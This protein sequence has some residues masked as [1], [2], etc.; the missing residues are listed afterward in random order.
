MYGPPT[1]ETSE[2]FNADLAK[3]FSRNVDKAKGL[4]KE[5][6]VTGPL[7]IEFLVSQAPAVYM[8][9]AQIVVANLAQIGVT[10]KI[11][12]VDFPTVLERKNSGNY[13]MIL[14]GASVRG[15][16]PD[17]AYGY[18]FG[19]G[20]GYWAAGAGF[21]DAELTELL[22]AGRAEVDI[23]KRKDIYRKLEKRV[24]ELSPWV[25]LTWRDD[26]VAYKSKLKGFAKLEGGLSV[27][28]FWIS[29]PKLHWT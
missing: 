25:F 12:T 6:G 1:P 26:A 15:P 2:F 21:K 4:L 16:D 7:Q 13:Q 17:I 18:Y 8:T 9:I 28:A 11:V 3:S 20:T 29:A 23:Q 22:A 27:P 19:P 24:L 14:Y 10:A 5:A